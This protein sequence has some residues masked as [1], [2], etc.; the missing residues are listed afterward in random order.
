M[1]LSQVIVKVWLAEQSGF[2][3]FVALIRQEY[4]TIS[5]SLPCLLVDKQT[6]MCV[7]ESNLVDSSV[8]SIT[9]LPGVLSPHKKDLT[10]VGIAFHFTW[11][12][13]A[14]PND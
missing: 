3:R 9:I 2:A 8:C 1:E 11:I 14:Y 6:C 4:T 7:K 12:P 10:M 13:T 5:I